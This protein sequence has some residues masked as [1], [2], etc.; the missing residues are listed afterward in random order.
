MEVNKIEHFKKLTWYR[1]IHIINLVWNIIWESRNTDGLMQWRDRNKLHKLTHKLKTE[2]YLL[3][4]DD[5]QF[6][7]SIYD[8]YKKN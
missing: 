2:S 3:T 6:L 5:F 7:E 4:Y 1:Q 8:K